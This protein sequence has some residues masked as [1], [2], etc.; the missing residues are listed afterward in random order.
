LIKSSGV[1]NEFNKQINGLN[2]VINMNE[3]SSCSWYTHSK[4]G[5]LTL[6]DSYNYTY[7]YKGLIPSGIIRIEVFGRG[8]T[9]GRLWYTLDNQENVVRMSNTNLSYDNIILN[10]EEMYIV[11]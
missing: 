2:S 4:E 9:A 7:A 6:N 5:R 8:S 3:Y 11:S 1:K 10:N